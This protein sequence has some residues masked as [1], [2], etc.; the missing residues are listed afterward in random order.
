MA[1][2][3]ETGVRVLF[4]KRMVEIKYENGEHRWVLS[5]MGVDIPKNWII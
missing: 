3:E 5:K 1:S 4:F 2:S